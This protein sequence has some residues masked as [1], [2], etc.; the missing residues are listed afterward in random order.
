[1][2]AD[3]PAAPE[4]SGWSWDVCMGA[5]GLAVPERS[6]WSWRV[7]SLAGSSGDGRLSERAG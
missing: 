5:D 1:M 3:A 6:G 4:R 7:R 2:G